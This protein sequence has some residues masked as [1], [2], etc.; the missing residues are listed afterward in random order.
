MFSH[1]SDSFHPH[2]QLSP[3]ESRTF[4]SFLSPPPVEGESLLEGA[5]V[6]FRGAEGQNGAGFENIARSKGPDVGSRNYW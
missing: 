4:P 6:V 3:M 5:P 1:I 2:L